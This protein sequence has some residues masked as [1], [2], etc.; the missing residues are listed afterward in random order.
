MS[1]TFSLVI[2]CKDEE[3]VIARCIEAINKDLREDDEI[4]VVDTGSSD[5]TL[6]I[7]STIKKVKVCHFNWSDNFA[8]ARNFGISKSSKDWIFFVDSDEILVKGSLNN[9]NDAIEEIQTNSKETD[10]FAFAPKIVNTDDSILYNAGRIVPNDNTVVFAG[11]IHEYPI[12]VEGRLNLVSLKLPTV[13]VNHDGYDET[14]LKNKNKALRNTTLIKEILEKTPNNSRYYYFYY[15]D[16]KPILTDQEYEK[17]LLD[18][19]KKFPS[20]TYSNQVIKDLAIF[21]LEHFQNDDAEKYI[22]ML[23]EYDDNGSSECRYAAIYLTGINEIQKI[24]VQQ[25]KL[26]K[27]MIH[28]RDNALKQEESLFE[29]G[30][31]FD[32]LIGELFFQLEDYKTAKEIATELSS[33][34]FP[35]NLAKTFKKLDQL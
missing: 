34:K 5:S 31:A 32:D 3:R 25:N 7:L 30:Y 9:L 8:E 33:V 14:V 11:A 23:L 35:S 21:Y 18:F 20:D 2:I 19:F 6:S 24:R 12:V 29:N 1:Q 17:G 15:R 27:L 13:V 26:L 28:G 10:R 22:N 4:I 16:A